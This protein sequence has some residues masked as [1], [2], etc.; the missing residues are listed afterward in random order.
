MIVMGM[1]EEKGAQLFKCDPAGYY[2]GYRACA[3]GQKDQE[4]LNFLEKKLKNPDTE[5]S[6]EETTQTAIMA[7]QTV[8]ATD[9]KPS[10]VEVAVVSAKRPRFTVLSDTEVEGHLTALSERD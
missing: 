6:E 8:L 9:F 4:A 1:D 3:A 5:M 7:F 2:V 10:D